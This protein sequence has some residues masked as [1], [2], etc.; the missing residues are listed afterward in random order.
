MDLGLAI[1]IVYFTKRDERERMRVAERDE[2]ERE[3]ERARQNGKK[4]LK[5]KYRG[6]LKR[7]NSVK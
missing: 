4:L 7:E 2:R 1:N 5:K 6:R 3:N